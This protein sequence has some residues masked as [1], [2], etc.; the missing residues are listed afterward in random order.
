[1]DENQY[2]VFYLDNEEYAIDIVKIH[3]INRLK[4]ITITRVPRVPHFIEGIINLRGE[5][6]PIINLRKKFGI[7]PKNISKESRIVIV[8][9]FNKVIGLLVDSVSHVLTFETVEI[10]PPPEEIK[11][12]CDYITGLGKKGKRMIFLLDIEKILHM[13][14]QQ[15]LQQMGA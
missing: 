14:E 7:D 5:V 3:E 1:M 6:V 9:I 4:E 8:K 10:A 11:I 13:E 12:S 2:V 15:E